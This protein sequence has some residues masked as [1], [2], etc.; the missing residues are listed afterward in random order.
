VL[1]VDVEAGEWPFLRSA[2]YDDLHQL[3]NVRQ[4]VLE[5]HTPRFKHQRLSKED[6]V[7]MILYVKALAAL[8]FTVFQSTQRNVCCR[9]F[10]AMMPPG[11]PEKC[12]QE[13]YYVKR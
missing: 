8:G 10:A 9:R 4:L 2:V 12:C 3:D 13:I 6:A 5:I 11:V 1:K 7:E